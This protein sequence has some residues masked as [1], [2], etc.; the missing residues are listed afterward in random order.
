VKEASEQD[1]EMREGDAARRERQRRRKVSLVR[2]QKQGEKRKKELQKTH[3]LQNRHLH[4]TLLKVSRLVLHH[5]DRDDL[6]RLEVLT[7]DD[8]TK[9]SLT[10]DVEDEVAVRWGR[11]DRGEGRRE[12]G[13][14]ERERGGERFSEH[15]PVRRSAF[16]FSRKKR[17]R[18]S[19]KERMNAPIPLLR[20]QHIVDIQDVIRVLVIEP[21]VLSGLRRFRQDSARVAR[22]FVVKLRVDEGVG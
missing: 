9:R 15:A 13:E 12:H 16:A 1:R 3:Q 11:R 22:C 6:V 17:R 20:T 18:T 14:H 7:F 21:I 10:E 2:S 4:H 19:K 5:L 8:L